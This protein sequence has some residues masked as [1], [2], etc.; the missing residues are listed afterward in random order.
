MK[1][2]DIW[3]HALKV[4]LW[5]GIDYKPEDLKELA[6]SYDPEL[7]AAPLVIDHSFFGKSYGWFDQIETRNSGKDLYMHLSEIDPWIEQDI[8]S[9]HYRE[10]SIL[11]SSEYPLKEKK[12]II[13]GSLLG[14]NPP[15]AVGKEPVYLPFEAQIEQEMEE[16]EYTNESEPTYDLLRCTGVVG[17]A[18]SLNFSTVSA[19]NKN[20]NKE[21][22]M[23][24][25]K[26]ELEALLAENTKNT[27]DMVHEAL[28]KKEEESKAL[29]NAQIQ[30]QVSGQLDSWISSKKILPA[31]KEKGLGQILSHLVDKEIEVDGKNQNAYEALS[32][33][34][35]GQTGHQL[36]AINLNKDDIPGPSIKPEEAAEK[37]KKEFMNLD[38]DP[39][40]ASKLEQAKALALNKNIPLEQALQLV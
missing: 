26:E 5:N 28:S 17:A 22:T 10:F 34:I 27:M 19:N 8:L 9:H 39:E 18:L 1:Q 7:L 16:E 24:V 20:P 25:T 31:H 32:S 6:G 29:L 12:Y 36:F 38:V 2:V 14:A 15:G 23:G 13:H 37:L 21:K 4:G 33:L 3:I 40:E 35:D 11:W 30:T